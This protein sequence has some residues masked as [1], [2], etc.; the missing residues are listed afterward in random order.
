VNTVKIGAIGLGGQATGHLENL[1]GFDDVE[2]AGMC[3]ISEP[4]AKEA[5]QR[6][7]GNPYTDYR[8][9][10]DDQELDAVY[11]CT[12]PFAHGK[13][14]LLACKREI[15]FFVEKPI[16]T[17][18]E[19]VL[20]VHEAV[21]ENGIITS[22][23]YHWRYY[24]HTNRAHSALEAATISGA[25]GCWM[26]GMPRVPWWRVREESG[27][28]HV[29]QTTH[30]FD[31]CRYLVAS[32]AVAVHGFAAQG[33][34]TDV[35]NY[36]VDDMSVVNIQFAN[37]VVANITSACM[38]EGWD[39][40]KLEVFCRGLV[41]TVHPG[42]VSINRT[43]ETESFDNDVS[44]SLDQD[45]IFIDAVKRGDS[46]EILAPYREALKTLEISLA[47]TESFAQGKQ[48]DL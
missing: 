1:A 10:Y 15:P 48:I 6:F 43:G 2:F 44:G 21:Q 27:G 40:V 31:L 4:R 13:Q 17:C 29:E 47:A 34:M 32:D 39:R 30:V 41:V 25:L 18:L 5:S 12:P 16:G 26:G 19:Q 46:S 28:Q 38:L 8:E 23:G 33:S 36:D 42:S 22:V 37:G 11:I 20:E 24:S 9:M 14:E 35:P 45:R 3:D 7:G